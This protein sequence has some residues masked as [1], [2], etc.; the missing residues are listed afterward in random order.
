[1]QLVVYNNVALCCVEMFAN[2]SRISLNDPTML[3][4]VLR[5]QNLREQREAK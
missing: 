4:F 3:H 1:M 2:V 5:A